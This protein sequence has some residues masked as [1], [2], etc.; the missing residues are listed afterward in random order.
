MSDNKFTIF[1]VEDSDIQRSMMADHLAKYKNVEVVT[2]SG[3]DYCLKDLIFEKVQPPELILMDYFLDS[4]TVNAKDGLETLAKLKEIA[5]YTNVIM[6]TSVENKRIMELA[7]QKGAMDYIFKGQ[8]S[9]EKLD[10]ILAREFSLS[11][12]GKAK[13]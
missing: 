7:K 8:D 1:V 3:G 10:E 12:N 6:F 5:P 2:Y 11:E 13:K 9:Y 4:N